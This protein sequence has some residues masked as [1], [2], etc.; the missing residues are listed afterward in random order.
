MRDLHRALAQ[1][2]IAAGRRNFRVQV[3]PGTIA[4][5][6][7]QFEEEYLLETRIGAGTRTPRRS[8]RP[9]LADPNGLLACNVALQSAESGVSE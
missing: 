1:I 7:K 2:G 6:Y 4:K 8:R 3:A 9:G 5:V